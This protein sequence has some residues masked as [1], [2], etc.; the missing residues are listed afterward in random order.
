MVTRTRRV[1]SFTLYLAL[2]ASG[3]MLIEKADLLSRL[4]VS[5]N[6]EAVSCSNDHCNPVRNCG[7]C[8]GFNNLVYR[9]M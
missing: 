7:G 9:P 5:Q 8:A 1:L 3:L 4:G 6:V 2:F